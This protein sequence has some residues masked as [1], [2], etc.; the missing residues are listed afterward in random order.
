M[1][2]EW[3]SHEQLKRPD[4]ENRK[5]KYYTKYF[6]SSHADFL[7]AGGARVVPIDYQMSTR[8]LS[9]LL[10]QLNGVY[11]PGDTKQS[12]LNEEY[13]LAI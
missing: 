6:E 7:Q 12:Y 8:Q 1:P 9:K 2:Q 13:H 5:D 3:H 11:I 10:S 4:S